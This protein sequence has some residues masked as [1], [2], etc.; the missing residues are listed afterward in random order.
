MLQERIKNTYPVVK[1]PEEFQEENRGFASCCEIEMVVADPSSNDTWKN[2][3]KSAWIKL[4]ASTDTCT[5]TLTDLNDVPTTYV[6]TPVAFVEEE[7]AFYTTV[8]WH[9]VIYS[10]GIGCYKLVIDYEIGGLTGSIVWGTYQ[11]IEWSIEALLGTARLRSIF[12]LRQ[13]IE[14]INFT[15]SNVEDTIRFFGQI[16][17]DQPNME[18]EELIYGNRRME[19]V[20][21]E[22]LHSWIM[23]TDPLSDEILRKFENLYLLSSNE[24]FV[25]DHNAHTNSYRIFDVPVKV[26][27]SPEREQSER[28]ARQ[29]VLKCKLFDRVKNQRTHY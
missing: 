4:A 16:R 17:K 11:L 19:T 28:Y 8:K 3:I 13:E 23:E 21:N 7:N 27:E 29:E 24:L 14:G 12:N 20:I 18:I 25:S 1:L 10:D 26:S 15:G 5:F 9:D 6:C 2:D 22:N